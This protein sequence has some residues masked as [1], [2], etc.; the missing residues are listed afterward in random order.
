[1]ISAVGALLVLVGLVSGAGP[2]KGLSSFS[3]LPLTTTT[4][5][6]VFVLLTAKLLQLCAGGARQ[7]RRVNFHRRARRVTFGLREPLGETEDS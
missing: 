6:L 3:L 7:D 2:V 4:A 5:L 1:M